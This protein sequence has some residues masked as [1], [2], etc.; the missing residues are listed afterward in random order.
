MKLTITQV[1]EIQVD[2]SIKEFGLHIDA[3]GITAMVE[4]EDCDEDADFL[5]SWDDV[6][7]W[8]EASIQD[9]GDAEAIVCG[10]RGVADKLEAWHNKP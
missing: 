1:E 9:E 2:V 3:N 10:L 7:G 4:M 6:L 8:A 5:L